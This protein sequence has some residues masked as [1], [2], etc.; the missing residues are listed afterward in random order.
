[1]HRGDMPRLQ[2]LGKG[3]QWRL[4][5]GN[6]EISTVPDRRTMHGELDHLYCLCRSIRVCVIRNVIS[7][8]RSNK[9]TNLM[10]IAIHRNSSAHMY[11]LESSCLLSQYPSQLLQYLAFVDSSTDVRDQESMR[12]K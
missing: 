9:A 8:K 12:M 3:F 4:V 6:L 5:L 1:M 7:Q 10:A 2:R 11:N